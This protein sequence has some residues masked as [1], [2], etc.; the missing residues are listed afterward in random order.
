[1]ADI[2]Y[3]SIT[4]WKTADLQVKLWM[5]NFVIPDAGNNIL[6]YL[7]HAQIYYSILDAV[8]AWPYK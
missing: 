6:D 3:T 7:L 5:I 2:Q 4:Q 1:M 8:Y